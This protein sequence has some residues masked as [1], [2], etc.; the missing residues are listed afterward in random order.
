MSCA[1]LPQPN[2][3]AARPIVVTCTAPVTAPVPIP[4]PAHIPDPVP[5]SVSIVAAQS[6]PSLGVPVPVR[7]A[8]NWRNTT[9][10]LREGL[11]RPLPFEC[12]TTVRRHRQSVFQEMLHDHDLGNGAI[13]DDDLE[14]G[15]DIDEILPRSRPRP[16]S[17]IFLT[18]FLRLGLEDEDSVVGA[19][20][21]TAVRKRMSWSPAMSPASTTTSGVSRTWS[22]AT[23]TTSTTA[24][25]A[26]SSSGMTDRKRRWYAKLG[27]GGSLRLARKRSVLSTMDYTK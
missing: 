20:T 16:A 4:I 7:P 23:G 24:T 17:G 21:P 25:T 2:P 22:M 18:N 1:V 5:L 19:D 26:S 27:G 13:D 14:Y 10:R 3:L 8:F 6:T 11:H 12:T 9:D 15:D